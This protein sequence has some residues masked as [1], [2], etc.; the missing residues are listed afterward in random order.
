MLTAVLAA[1]WPGAAWGQ[2][3]DVADAA[4]R[5]AQ[6]RFEEGLARVKA[7]D[8]EAARLSFAQA[9]VVLARPAILWNLALAEEKTGR[10]VPALGHFKRVASD[11]DAPS[12]DRDEAGRHVDALMAR[13]GHVG[14]EAPSGAIIHVDGQEGQAT[15]PLAEPIDVAAGHCVLEAKLGEGVKAAAVDVA[16]GQIVHV[17][18]TLADLGVASPPVFAP[19]ERVAPH[20]D[21]SEPRGSVPPTRA[22]DRDQPISTARAVT[23]AAV[24]GA[25]LVAA[26]LGIYFGLKSESDASQADGFRTSNA[27]APRSPSSCTVTPT[28]PACPALK[29]AVDSENREATLARAFYVGAA[30]LAGGAIATWF[31]WPKDAPTVS[32]A[33]A[34]LVPAVG[35]GQ[36]G[37][38]AE[39]RF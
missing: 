5:D 34:W 37:L 35:P 38:A 1:A 28:D 31:L 27:T 7:G 10:L 8:Y 36:A 3:A 26:G 4:A 18:F 30:V 16:A 24:G 21:R 19:S 29:N 11:P 14:V 15:A 13:T 33:T 12:P 39:G 20:V 17:R 2:A 6:A 9:Y 23:V 32:A 22:S 25:A